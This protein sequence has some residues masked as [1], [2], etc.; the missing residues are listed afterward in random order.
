MDPHQHGRLSASI[1]RA[2][3]DLIATR[4]KDPRVQLVSISQVELNRDHSQARIYVAITGDE[5]DRQ[6]SLVGL[7]RAAGFL[8]RQL[9]QVL[10][11]RTVPELRFAYDDSLDR[12]LGMERV[13]REL[14][15]KGEFQDPRARYRALELADLVPPRELV[16][17][18]QAAGRVWLTGHWN[19]DPDSVGATLAL[20]AALADLDK[21]VVAFRF[22]DPGPGLDTLPGWADAVPPEEAPARF[23]AEPP[24]VAVLLDCHRTDRCGPLQET[25]DR[26]ATVLCVDHHLITGRRAPVPGW[27]DERAESTCTL[28]YRVIQALTGD[29]PAAI[30]VDLATNLF[31]GLAGDTGGFRFDNVRPATFRLAAELAARGVDTA[32]V[33]HRLLHQR[34]REGLALLQLALAGL[35]YAG[36]GRVAVMRIT[37][38]MRAATRAPLTETEGFVNVLTSVA[39]VRYAALLKELDTGVWRVSLRANGGDVQAV[40]ARFGGG[41]HR[42]AA[43]CTVEGDGDSV[44]AAITAALLEA[45]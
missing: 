42:A 19:P 41:G 43:G 12:G 26:A 7:H 36:G 22:P 21:D 4:V 9:G 35:A 23:A 6:K 20:A 13:L 31:A 38:E 44:A 24:D 11:L 25:L 28:V 34:Q 37:R 30:G 1:Q 27:V 5:T 2:L 40:A 39:G 45:E 17:P 8:Q 15:D 3:S 18:L 33:Q 16:E 29:D 32:G 10:R 14:A